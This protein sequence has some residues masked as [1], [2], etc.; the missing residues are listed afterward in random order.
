MVKARCRPDH[1]GRCTPI[2]T[3][4]RAHKEA[5]IGVYRPPGSP[6]VLAWSTPVHSIGIASA[7]TR[8][9][10]LWGCDNNLSQPLRKLQSTRKT[11]QSRP[12]SGLWSYTL[13]PVSH[14]TRLL[15]VQV[16]T[17]PAAHPRLNT[18]APAPTIVRCPLRHPPPLLPARPPHPPSPVL[19]SCFPLPHLGH[20]CST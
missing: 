5:C 14:W 12:P 15:G 8:C 4:V 13:Y 11:D 10:A 9:S 3:H 1:T 6:P 17:P 7:P 19:C 20:C 2:P 16:H 18:S